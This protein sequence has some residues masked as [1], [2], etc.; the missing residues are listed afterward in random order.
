MKNSEILYKMLQNR[1]EAVEQF[2]AMLELYGLLQKALQGSLYG[3]DIVRYNSILQATVV[4]CR[5]RRQL[6]VR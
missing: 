6:C 4:D 3:S 1:E 5:L 2:F